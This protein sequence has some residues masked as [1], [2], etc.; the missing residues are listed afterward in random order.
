MQ[1]SGMSRLQITLSAMKTAVPLMLMVV[2]IF[3]HLR[4]GMQVMLE[5]YVHDKGL[6]FFSMLLLNFYAYA[7]AAAGVA[8]ASAAMPAKV[9]ASGPNH[10]PISASRLPS[11]FI[12]SMALSNRAFSSVSD[13]RIPMPMPSPRR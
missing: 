5:D 11:A 13:W 3:M 12:S 7:G 6:A 9:L 1:A 4:L 2:S 10:L 8:A